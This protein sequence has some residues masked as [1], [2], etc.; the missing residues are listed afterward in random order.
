MQIK[1]VSVAIEYFST[2]VEAEAVSS[3]T[4]QATKKFLLKNIVY[5]FRIPRVM[6]TNSGTQFRGRAFKWACQK[7]HIDHLS[8]SIVPSQTNGQ[9]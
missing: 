6:I 5:R 2:W 8:S 7:L 4:D 1:F 3:I 9:V